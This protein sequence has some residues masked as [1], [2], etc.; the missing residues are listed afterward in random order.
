M[1]ERGA[2]L[3]AA[4]S[5]AIV[6]VYTQAK[7]VPPPHDSI[8]PLAHPELEV[9]GAVAPRPEGQAAS[10]R[11]RVVS[12]P[13][14]TRVTTN[15]PCVGTEISASYTPEPKYSMR[16]CLGLC[17]EAL[18]H[19]AKRRASLWLGNWW[20]TRQVIA[21]TSCERHALQLVRRQNP[22][23]DRQGRRSALDPTLNAIPNCQIH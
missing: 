6:F 11:S 7:R 8:N 12:E 15:A 3:R 21:V 2:P 19:A 5:A 1:L 13:P 20:S 14:R 10:P 22:V 16:S 17:P 23:E 4:K 18:T 9:E